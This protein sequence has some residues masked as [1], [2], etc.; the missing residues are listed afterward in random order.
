MS[1]KTENMLP[2]DIQIENLQKSEYEK[3][4]T[5]LTDAFESNPAYAL[6]FTK[7]EKLRD[8]LLWLF[9]TNLFLINRRI[10]V[11][12][13]VKEKESGKIIGVFSLLPPGGAKARFSDYLQIGLSRFVSKFGFQTLHKM[14]GMDSYNKKLLTKA[15][16]TNEYYYLSM[17][18]IKE[19]Y[20]G[21]GI[22]S[23]MITHSLDELRQAKGKSHIVGLTTQ[24]PE[25]VTFY[26]RLGFQKLDEGEVQFKQEH[27][28]N[29]NMKLDL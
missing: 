3:V 11:K 2:F 29:Y 7:K 22:G 25:N 14:L 17:V 15:M 27:Y 8:G 26:S 5:L 9:R 10:S 6:I 13:V 24:L 4:S 19:E 21:T 16:G 12:K 20:R 1:D 28:Y 23:F 18:A